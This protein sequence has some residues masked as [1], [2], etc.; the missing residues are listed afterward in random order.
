MAL[1]AGFMLGSLNKIWPWR[2][3]I[4]TRINSSGEEVPFLEKSVLPGA[5]EGDAQ[6]TGVII[7]V[8]IGFGLV[9]ILD[10]FGKQTIKS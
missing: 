9:F 6:V 2:N 5:F 3:V 8:L 4:S 1:L 7:L 10:R